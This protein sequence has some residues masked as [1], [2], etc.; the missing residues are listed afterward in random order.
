MLAVDGVQMQPVVCHVVMRLW[1]RTG[2]WVVMRSFAVR[3][4]VAVGVCGRK[5]GEGVA[6][7]RLIFYGETRMVWG[8]NVVLEPV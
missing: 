7:R 1:S 4:A 3:L 6:F 8:G 2:T 5:G